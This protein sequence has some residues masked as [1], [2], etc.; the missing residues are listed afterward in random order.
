MTPAR[1]LCCR[2][3]SSSWW[4]SSRGR[5]RRA[6]RRSPSPRTR[7]TTSG[8]AR[9]LL[10]GRGLCQRRAVELPDAA[11]ESSRDPAFEVWLPLPTF[12]AAIPMALF[13]TTFAAAQVSIGHRRGLVPVLAWRLA[14]DVAEER[15]LSRERSRSVALGAG[16]TSAVYLPLLLNSAL[17]DS[18]MPFAV[19][20]LGAYLLM[21]RIVR[22]PRGARLTD[23][24]LIAL[25]VLL[26]LGA[27]TRNEI[28][29]ARPHLGGDG[30]VRGP[31]RVGGDAD[32]AHRRRRRS[33]PLVVFAP[34]AYRNLRELG[35]PVARPGHHQRLLPLGLRHLRL[36]RPADPGPL[37]RPRSGPPRRDARSKVSATTSSTCS[38]CWACRS[39]SSGCVALP[40]QGRGL[41]L[42]PLLWMSVITFLVHQPASSRRP[43]SGA[44]SC[45]PP[46]P[47]HVLLV[48]S[49]ML[50]LDAGIARLGGPDGLDQAGR[51]ARAGPRHL[52]LRPVLRGLC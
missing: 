26:G 14:A 24:R 40:W 21:T 6:D 8:V 20:V 39:R 45:T 47:V 41:S 32:P 50:A 34:W 4:P 11:A 16:L 33:W 13:G 37:P 12:L 52:R 1:G 17:P 38:C 30:L 23:P 43:P 22:D 36:E 35:T 3:C 31:G 5:R 29:L 51:L 49:A 27:L 15:G 42:R 2:P 46:G 19:I 44:P 9:N 7:P 25:G 28:D 18:T 10:E 48:I